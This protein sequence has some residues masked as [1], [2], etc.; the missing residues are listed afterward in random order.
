MLFGEVL[1][2]LKKNPAIKCNDRIFFKNGEIQL[3]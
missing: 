3:N 1:N 2:K